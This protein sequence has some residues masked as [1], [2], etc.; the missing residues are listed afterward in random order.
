MNAQCKLPIES[1]LNQHQIQIELK[2]NGNRV[3]FEYIFLKA[4]VCYPLQSERVLAFSDFAFD[5]LIS[6]ECDGH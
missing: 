4:K 6:F 2:L 5:K 1:R 3:A